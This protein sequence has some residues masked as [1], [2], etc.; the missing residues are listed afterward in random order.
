MTSDWKRSHEV[1]VALFRHGVPSESSPRR[2][3]A[4]PWVSVAHQSQAP[5]GRQKKALAVRVIVREIS[6]APAGAQI[7]F[8][9]HTHGSLR[10]AVGYFLTALRARETFCPRPVRTQ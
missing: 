1:A 2:S 7:L 8:F 6:P 3:A 4:K 10:F 5:E 9:A